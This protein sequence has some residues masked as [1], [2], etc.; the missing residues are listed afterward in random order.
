MA[1][2]TWIVL[3]PP[4]LVILTTILTKR[5]NIAFI[6]SILTAAFI[7]TEGALWPALNLT[8]SRSIHQIK[9]IDYLYLYIFLLLIGIFIT[10]LE[11]TGGALAFAHTFTK[12]I[13]SKKAAETSSLLVSAI[14][15]VD[16]YLSNLTVGYV[17]S[18]ITDAFRI[19]RAKL[20]YLVHSI[21][22]PLIMIMP[23][24]SWVAM[25]TG[26]L[27]NAGIMTLHEAQQMYTPDLKI[28]ADPYIV[29]L[30]TI[31]F[32]FYSFLAL[33]SVILIVRYRI[34]FGPMHT[35]ERIASTTGNLFG[36][37]STQLQA[38]PA[39]TSPARDR[40]SQKPSLIDFCIP[41]CILIIT[42]ITTLLYTGGYH[43]F[44]GSNSFIN[45]FK[46]TDKSFL[47]I[48]IAGCMC[49]VSALLLALPRHKIT[50]QDLPKI[51]MAG[52]HMMFPA[53]IMLILATILST[54]VYQ[55]LHTGT[56][57]AHVLGNALPPSLVPFIFFIVASATAFLMGTSWGTIA[58]LLPMAVPMMIAFANTC[59]PTTPSLIPLLLPGLG[60]IFSG[61]ACG[62]QISPISQTTLMVATSTGIDPLTHARTQIPYNFPAFIAATCAFLISGLCVTHNISHAHTLVCS[63]IS[64]IVIN[65]ALLAAINIMAQVNRAK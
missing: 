24:S 9:D 45:A 37:K 3:L 20:A 23:I 10:L 64:G 6:I 58:L 42:F 40:I 11:K 12:H 38:D 39:A 19:P 1:N 16:D 44:G 17:M 47:A 59:L 4:V 32:I 54:I 53:I 61:A 30:N 26:Q 33:I 31:P 48:C 41:L 49:L 35:L 22:I 36:K 13:R 21:S 5:L 27:S 51:I 2:P 65:V 43:I 63:L 57:L 50:L 25:L 56:Y 14:L 15:F 18:P 28:I 52:I 62:D 7:A 46:N 8:A 60:A 29:F 55:D 34:S